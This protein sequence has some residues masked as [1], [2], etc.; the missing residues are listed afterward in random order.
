MAIIIPNVTIQNGADAAAI[1]Q[2][3][4][5]A[6]PD[7]ISVTNA[8]LIDALV[9][10]TSDPD[11]LILLTTL[12]GSPPE[13]VQ[14]DE[15]IYATSSIESIQRISSERLDGR[16]FSVGTPSPDALNS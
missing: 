16:A 8:S 10:D 5:S 4:I 12:L 7:G 14:L 2:G 11:D 13:A 1:H 9:Y 6:Y 3:P 15:D